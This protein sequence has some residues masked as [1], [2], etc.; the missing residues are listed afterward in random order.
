MPLKTFQDEHPTLNLMPMIDVVFQLVLF[1]LVGSRFTEMERSMEVKLPEVQQSARSPLSERPER[2]IIN[3]LRDGTIVFEQLPVNVTE[4]KA[5]L[6]AARQR[7]ADLGVIVRGDGKSFHENVV[8][9][10]YTCKSAGIA[11]TSVSVK[12]TD[13]EP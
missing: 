6:I 7:Y 9:V 8:R 1:L 3:V 10:L 2:A 12:L 4:L 11:E 13:V 5:R